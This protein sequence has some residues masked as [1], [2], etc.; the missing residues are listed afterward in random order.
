MTPR[1][2]KPVFTFSPIDEPAD[3]IVP[4]SDTL[5]LAN[6]NMVHLPLSVQE[7]NKTADEPVC[8]YTEKENSADSEN[9][10]ISLTEDSEN[11]VLSGCAFIQESRG[12]L[13]SPFKKY[14]IDREIQVFDESAQEENTESSANDLSLLDSEQLI[15]E[16]LL[17]FLDGKGQDTD[18]FPHSSPTRP[19]PPLTKSILFETSL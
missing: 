7:N 18:C 8:S 16:S 5:Q 11:S 1:C 9:S 13:T 17:E 3:D 6:M 4:N 10:D 19:S 12:S 2:R 15:S 14:L